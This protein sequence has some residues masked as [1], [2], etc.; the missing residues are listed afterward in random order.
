M[1]DPMERDEMLYGATDDWVESDQVLTQDDAA[2]RWRR[3]QA[4]QTRIDEVSAMFELERLRLDERQAEVL[5]PLERS[6]DA[7]VAHVEQW[8]RRYVADD[9][10]PTIQWPSGGSTLVKK[11]GQAELVVTDEGKLE[12]EME[13]LGLVD[14][15][16]PKPPPSP[17]PVRK[18]NRAALR[19]ALKALD[20]KA[21]PGTPV[22]LVDKE[23]GTKI[24]GAH[25][26]PKPREFHPTMETM[27]DDR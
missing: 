23:T 19:K 26:V 6:R 18:L 3:A 17:P 20:P 25:L 24:E 11:P 16:F 27:T 15:V 5:G 13:E 22:P 10:V 9:G 14:V 12:A 2:R 7:L 8:H 4:T 21:E 1:T